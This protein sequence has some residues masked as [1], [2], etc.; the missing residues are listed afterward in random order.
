MKT[1][2]N[3]LL[4]LIL[5]SAGLLPGCVQVIEKEVIVEKPVYIRLAD[6]A[7]SCS[8]AKTGY[9]TAPKKSDGLIARGS[10]GASAAIPAGTL[11]ASQFAMGIGPGMSLDERE[12][13][14]RKVQTVLETS[15]DG[16]GVR[17][18]SNDSGQVVNFVAS[19]TFQEERLVT[20]QRGEEVGRL[21]DS[22]VVEPAI[23]VTT[24]SATLRPTPSPTSV[25][26]GG[27]VPSGEK[28]KVL[29]RVTGIQSDSWFLVGGPD[30]T[31]Y[32]YLETSQLTP[33]ATNLVHPRE[34]YTKPTGARVRDSLSASVMCRTLVYGSSEF[35]NVMRTC[36][37]PGGRWIAEPPV[38][39]A[40]GAC[41][42]R[43]QPP[44]LIDEG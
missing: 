21:P 34:I 23:Y 16:E 17:W 9:F 38:V 32:G 26:S 8:P 29:G 2:P 39:D 22:L 28:V 20:V 24:E 11:V 31:A 12:V 37:E 1:R 19:D 7:S 27:Q 14:E 33:N 36:R 5:A 44:F 18:V 35:D 30:G 13:L 43:P 15:S 6:E 42:A 40:R 3:P 10:A 41:N 25:V 4:P